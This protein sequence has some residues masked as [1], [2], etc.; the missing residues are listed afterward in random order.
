MSS[1]RILVASIHEEMRKDLRSALE[2]DGHEVT[3]AVTVAQTIH[4]ACFEIHDALILNC[5]MDEI[6]APRI[7]R[8]VRPKSDLGI[9]VLGGENATSAIDALNAGADDFVP[10][11]FVMGELLSR[12]RAIL[13]RVPRSGRNEIVL[14]DGTID[15]ES[16]EIRHRDGR[17]SHLTPKEFEVLQSLVTPANKPRT[18]Q[19]L[20]QTVWQRDGRGEVEY[21]RVV[22]GQLRRKLEPD[23]ENP[24]YI[25]TERAVG[26]RF[27]LPPVAGQNLETRQ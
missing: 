10:A 25:L 15:L 24:R 21:M 26:Y 19:S 11:P 8:A 12:V 9:I 1:G 3:E 27:N 13:R 6:A 2:F 16:R 14:P 20:A 7:C 17:V 4:E 5:V 23:P 22:V 18:H